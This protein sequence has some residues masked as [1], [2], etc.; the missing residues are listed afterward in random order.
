MKMMASLEPK[1]PKSIFYAGVAVIVAIAVLAT[2]YWGGA[3]PARGNATGEVSVITP[4]PVDEPGS[5]SKALGI[6]GIAPPVENSGDEAE[7]ADGV[8]LDAED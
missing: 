2:A 6:G 3:S 4:E 7:A 5:G 8:D 1:I